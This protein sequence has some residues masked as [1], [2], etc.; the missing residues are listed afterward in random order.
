MPM[1]LPGILELSRR[2]R[3]FSF[4]AFLLMEYQE[5]RLTPS[6]A[7]QAE[8]I[9]RCEWDLGLAV[10]RCPRHCESS[11]VGARK[12]RSVG[13]GP[14]PLPR[15][16][17]VESPLGGYGLYYRS[18]MAECGIVARAGTPLNGR[19]IPVDVVRDTERARRVAAGFKDAVQHTEYYRRAMRTSA[20]RPEETE[21]LSEDLV[22]EYAD[23]AC[24]C[25]L[26]DLLQE[27]AAVHDALFGVD[28][29]ETT[30]ASTE[31]ED[32]G[33]QDYD[34]PFSAET[35]SSLSG[36]TQRR[37]SVGH[38]LSLIG[39]DGMVVSSKAAY[40]KALWAPPPPRNAV[41]ARVAGQWAALIAK[42]VWQD[43][44]CSVWA[45][46][47]R[48]GL[49]R[50][51]NGRDY[52]RGLTWEQ[53]RSMVHG[54]AQGPPTLDATGQ[55]AAVVR[56]LEAKKFTFQD[57]DGL[58]VNVAQLSLESLRDLTSRLDSASSGLVVLLE[59]ARRMTERAGDGWDQASRLRSDWQWSIAQ[60]ADMLRAHLADEPTVADSLWWL[61]SRYIAP[62]HER[63]AY[64]KLPE[65][66]ICQTDQSQEVTINL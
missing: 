5:R 62:V 36:V 8:F 63:I 31:V 10:L 44:L 66:P 41:H 61:V 48:A 3:Y 24:L 11:P 40:R 18:P 1:L 43:A 20:A 57:V 42:D 13:D 21:P 39:A 58:T 52:H 7:A 60:V 49:A 25:R 23:V 34:G 51:D 29:A 15:G 56:L 2:A 30:A 6:R 37:R 9:R 14:G 26:R 32:E 22:A 47:C 19:P 33:L 38:Y 53:T 4:H 46:F 64:S 55:T 59:L 17:S 28:P 54:F 12:L 65:F 27:Q 16:E 50:R 45:E 35:R